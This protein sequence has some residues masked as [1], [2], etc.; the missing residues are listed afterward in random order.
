VHKREEQVA[1]AY[2]FQDLIAILRTEAPA[3]ADDLAREYRRVDHGLLSVGIKIHCLDGGQQFD[4][5]VASLGG[6]SDVLEINLYKNSRASLCLVLPPVG[7]ATSAIH[8]IECLEQFIKAPIFGNP[9]IQL[10]LCSP[11]RVGARAAALLGTGFYLGSDTLRR[12][13]QADLRTT[14]TSHAINPRG[15]RL[16]LYDAEGDFDRGFVWWNKHGGLEPELPFKNGRTDLL[17][18]SGSRL[19]IQNVNL[20]ATLL[21]HSEY[22]G[23]WTLLGKQ[24][25]LEMESLLD[26][27]ILA[28]LLD[29]PW[30]RE[31][32]AQIGDDDR[33]FAALGELVA[34]AFGE[35]TRVQERRFVLF[36]SWRDI[37]A[38]APNGILHEMQMLLSKYRT[39]LE[40]QS[41]LAS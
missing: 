17:I 25:A 39:L 15:I 6:V 11:G 4:R 37:P 31:R 27:H 32:S 18:G 21:I 35:S 5:L 3:V 16:V 28:G 1:C 41:Q 7:S 12:Y 13:T 26:R 30:I 24:F 19:D 29:A 33:F 14:F 2:R 38:R 9:N 40:R 23:Y 22:D 10:Q 8:L 34:Y 20:I 36:K